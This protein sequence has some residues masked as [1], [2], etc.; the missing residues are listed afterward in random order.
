[1]IR[2]VGS[3][4]GRSRTRLLA[5]LLVL[6]IIIPIIVFAFIHYLPLR[7]IKIG[8]EGVYKGE[9]LPGE[10]RILVKMDVKNEG[11][12]RHYYTSPES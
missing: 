1:M 4:E 2:A 9:E 3:T 5:V 8:V 6:V 10:K 12:I 7:D 11:A